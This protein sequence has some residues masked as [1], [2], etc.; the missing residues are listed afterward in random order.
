M[1][2]KQYGKK[3]GSQTLKIHGKEHFSKISKT[4]WAK[5]R[6]I[7]GAFNVGELNNP[8]TL[9]TIQDK[10]EQIDRDSK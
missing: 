4:A 1:T 5:R 10:L 6:L 2:P 9:K 3:G 8:V 7:L